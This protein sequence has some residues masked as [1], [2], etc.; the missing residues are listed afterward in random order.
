[1][2]ARFTSQNITTTRNDLRSGHRVPPVFSP[3]FWTSL[4]LSPQAQEAG[5]ERSPLCNQHFRC[6]GPSNRGLEPL[7]VPRGKLR[8]G[9]SPFIRTNQKIGHLNSLYSPATG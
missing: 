7:Q 5:R 9:S 8:R 3:A 1:M 2:T 4:D 6:C